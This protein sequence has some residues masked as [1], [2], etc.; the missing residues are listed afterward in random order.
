MLFDFILLISTEV[1]QQHTINNCFRG[2][3]LD[4]LGA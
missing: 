4:L 2:K 1:I 3:K